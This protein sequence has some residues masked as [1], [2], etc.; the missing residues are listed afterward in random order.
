M[1]LVEGQVNQYKAFID[2][3]SRG[4]P[5]LSASAFAL[6]LKTAT[7]DQRHVLTSGKYVGVTT[8]N[9]AEYLALEM[10]CNHLAETDAG[11]SVDVYCDSLLVVN[12][13]NGVW[14]TKDDNLFT[15]RKRIFFIARAGGLLPDIKH[16]PR[17]KNSEADKA[18]NLIMD[19]V[20][21][22]NETGMAPNKF[23]RDW[24]TP[25]TCS[26]AEWPSKFFTNL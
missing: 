26:P 25:I 3:G 12:Q 14:R 6:S 9:V 19:G 1:Y 24:E 23:M 10:L 2:G 11:C 20:Q 22:L 15:I 18:V 13:M 21:H 5:G 16:I 7:G 8:N 4:N 17:E